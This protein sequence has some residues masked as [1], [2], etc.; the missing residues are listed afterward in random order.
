MLKAVEGVVYLES[1]VDRAR[2]LVDVI[3]FS[4][5]IPEPFTKQ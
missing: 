2:S 3:F 4:T 5:E 1:Y